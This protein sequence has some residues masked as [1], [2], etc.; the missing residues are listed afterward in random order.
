MIDWEFEW[1]FDSQ[2]KLVFLFDWKF[3]WKFDSLDTALRCFCFRR[4]A[5]RAEAAFRCLYEAATS[6]YSSIG[7]NV[8]TNN[9]AAAA[10]NRR[11]VLL[12]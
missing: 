10:K 6:A 12:A 11:S 7:L 5:A 8:L 2:L 1:E 3:D 4:N 9:Q